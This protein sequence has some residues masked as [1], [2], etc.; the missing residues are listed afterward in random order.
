MNK[1]FVFIII[2][3][4]FS[5]C[6]FNPNS[7][8]WKNENNDLKK[9]KNLKKISLNKDEVFSEL[10]SSLKLDLSTI[11]VNQIGIENLN[12]YGSLNYAGQLDKVVSFKFKKFDNLNYLNF[13]PLF[14]KKGIIFF[15]NNGSVIFYDKNSK[16]IWKKNYYSKSEKKLN[17]KLNF[18]RIKNR[19]II[20][21]NIGKFYLIDISNGNLIWMKQNIYPFNSEIKNYK[22]KFFSVDY[23][24]ILR[25]FNIIDGSECWKYPTQDALTIS[26][27]KY[28]IIINQDLVIFNNSV[29][30]ITAVNFFD[31]NIEWQLPTQDNKIIN[32][33]YYF[34]NSKIVADSDKIYFSN[35][36]NKFFSVD[37]ETGIPDWTNK[38]N[39]YLTPILFDQYIFT[40][41][42][43]GFLYT[44]QRQEGNIIRINDIYKNYDRKHRAKLKPTGFSI[45]QDKL[46]L[47]N[48]DGS[49]SVINLE[50][51]NFIK[52]EKV[53][54]KTISE[55]FIY[56]K[57]LFIIKHGSIV[58]YK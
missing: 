57:S 10:N 29:G 51:G 8:I 40:V 21:D 23:K 16:I 25:C 6:S 34:K 38:I 39:S 49:I 15:D 44:I 1:I 4:F 20:T 50:M 14:L 32:E 53:S 9:N 26:N 46:Y 41:S 3:F 24:N 45:G 13:K 19:I 37:I 5:N 54:R 52:S 17:P 7:K 22:G 36:K 31:G 55:P 58:K 30:D 11:K 18:S 47:S 33:T 56:D 42:Q 43:E 28:S 2:S 27:V 35:N 12:N 48:N